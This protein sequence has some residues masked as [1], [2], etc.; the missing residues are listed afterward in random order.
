[1]NTATHAVLSRLGKPHRV[2]PLSDWQ[3]L[4]D[5]RS[6]ASLSI[7]AYTLAMVGRQEA[8]AD[9]DRIA[10][11]RAAAQ[12]MASPVWRAAAA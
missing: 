9:E 6:A 2:A 12:T 8:Q 11:Q 4:A 3:A 10:G 5:M 1:M 7:G